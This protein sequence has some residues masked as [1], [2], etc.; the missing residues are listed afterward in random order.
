MWLCACACEKDWPDQ[1]LVTQYV[2]F[3]ENKQQ[4]TQFSKTRA[5]EKEDESM[6][7]ELERRRKLKWR[8]ENSTQVREKIKSAWQKYA[9]EEETQRNQTEKEER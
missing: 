2:L 6:K 3:T 8:D 9:D 7:K 1:N 5:L 4:V